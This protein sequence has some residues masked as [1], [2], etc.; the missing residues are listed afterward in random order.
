[1]K[2]SETERKVL[3]IWLIIGVLVFLAVVLINVKPKISKTEQ[4]NTTPGENHVS[5]RIRYYTVKNAI[6]KYY[7]Y[8]NISD[9]DSVIKIL[10]S[11][12]V[13]KNH[14]DEDTV[15][16]FIGESN[17]MMT[18]ETGIMCLKS[19]KSGVYV[20]VV[21]GN[22]VAMS[23]GEVKNEMYYQITLDGNTSLFSLQP[24]NEEIYGGVCNE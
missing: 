16:T 24:I 22:E 2:I 10:D 14:I 20:Y 17:S 13:E 1:M 18:F 4:P 7:S 23:T 3:I 11:S 12:Y 21:E 19:Y 5:D 6:N 9:Y 15:T 8:K